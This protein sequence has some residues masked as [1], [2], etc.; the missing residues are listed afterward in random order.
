M[1]RL[2]IPS[3]VDQTTFDF[4]AFL[5]RIDR[6]IPT[7]FP[8]WTD[9][10]SAD[11]GRIFIEGLCFVGDV[12]ADFSN[13]QSREAHL[14]VCTQLVNAM[15]HARKLAY[16]PA[17]RS[18]AT[19]T[20][21]LTLDAVAAADVTATAGSIIRAKSSTADVTRVQ[22]TSDLLVT[23]GNLSN[24]GSAEHS[25]SFTHSFVSDGK[26]DQE[27][28]LSNIPFLS[29]VSVTDTIGAW[30]EVENFLD[31]TATDRH[32]RL[33][34]TE[35]DK[36]LLKF[37]DG[38]NGAVP[39]GQV[40]TVYKTGGGEITID[41]GALEIP[42]FSLTDALGNA[43]SFT[44]TNPA[45]SVG[46]LD[47]ETVDEIRVNAPASL[48]ATTRSI[49]KE[50]FE[51]NAKRV[52]G[53]ARALMLSADQD[54]GIAENTGQLYIVAKGAALSS[55]RYASATPTASQ[56]A[57]VEALITNTYPPTITFTF[58]VY[59]PVFNTVNIVAR[60]A[61]SQGANAATAD[62]TIRAAVADLFA[63]LNSDL[64][65]NTEIDFGYNYKDA[66]GAPAS[67]IPWSDLFNA[68]RDA[69]GVRAVDKATFQ[70]Y[71]D[72]ALNY[73]QFP[74]LGTVTLINDDTGLALV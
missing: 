4:D 29:V 68:V 45:A 40:D 16:T 57:E 42:E 17:G 63:A 28:E 55:G 41:A 27:A 53:I 67:A 54:S 61:L 2:V 9:R 12:V 18:A 32:Y 31:S 25:E 51:T 38:T 39:V 71:T 24:T 10:S 36:A 13:A 72:V 44:I 33:L 3:E 7:V 73:N 49:T 65:E 64:T 6:S 20:M 43:V 56:K 50:D 1:T 26:A 15:R 35:D 19:V 5:D 34:R 47:R 8:E 11:I 58:D 74:A 22:L 62:T 37:P 30:S 60:V 21:K 52:S 23:A 70:P 48:S 69:T 66:D 46:G 59:D 14:S